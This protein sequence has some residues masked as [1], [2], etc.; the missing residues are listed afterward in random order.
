MI[1]TAKDRVRLLPPLTITFE[2]IDEGIEILKAF[3]NEKRNKTLLKC[4]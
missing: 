2:E 4:T 1:L 3:L